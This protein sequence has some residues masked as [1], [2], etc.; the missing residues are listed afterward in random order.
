MSSI[1]SKS[2]AI[3]GILFLILIVPIFSQVN[4]K[5]RFTTINN[6][7]GLPN[8]TVNAIAKDDLGFI[9]IGTNDGLCR[10]ESSNHIKVFR[11]NN[12]EISGG[13]QSSNIR[14]LYLDSKNNL[15][16]GT[17]LGGLTKFHQPSGEW[18]TFRHDSNNSSSI[19]DDEILTITEDSKGRL[20]VGTEN[21]ISVY[22]YE[23]ESFFSFKADKKNPH[24][25]QTKAVLTIIEDDKG[26]I[27]AGTW[28]GGLHLLT[29]PENGDLEKARFRNFVLN[30]RAKSKHVWKIFQDDQK[31]YWVGSRG[32][33]LFLMQLPSNAN[34]TFTNNNWKP[35]FHAFIT[36]K[37]NTTG[38]SLSLIHI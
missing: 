30:N 4:S 18:K 34:N 7:D 8:N 23:T 33:G 2:S 12:P 3:T 38:I 6:V 14:S 24:A 22:N 13:L 25:L 17:R 21:G 15:W 29:L 37:S 32:A 20:W 36:D 9:W 27:W 28:G 16:I 5:I 19:S 11:A 26:W 10:Y 1:K 31:R 35:N